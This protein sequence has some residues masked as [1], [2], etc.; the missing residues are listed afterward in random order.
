ML[1]GC[2]VPGPGADPH[3]SPAFSAE[4][5][6]LQGRTDYTRNVFT[7]SVTNTGTGAMTVASAVLDS[8]SFADAASYDADPVTIGPGR[9]IDLRAPIPAVACDGDAELGSVELQVGPADAAPTTT[10]DVVPTDPNNTVERLVREGCIVHDVDAVVSIDPPAALVVAGSGAEATA[11][12]DLTLTPTGAPGCVAVDR[13]RSTTLMSPLDGADSWPLGLTIDAA[14]E[15]GTVSLAMRPTRCDPHALADDKVGTVL[16][17]D[18]STSTGRA[19]RYLLP[20]P[21]P[22]KAEVYAF[23]VGVCGD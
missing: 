3:P 7:L 13:V 4:V 15:P 8:P 2:T 14:S 18:V 17:L 9:T 21:P 16:V 6:I 23:I 10:L 1:A 19:G 12:I 5:E 22:V 20:L 11:R